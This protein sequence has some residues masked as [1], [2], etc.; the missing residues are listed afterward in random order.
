MLDVLDA[1][2]LDAQIMSKNKG[3][4]RHGQRGVDIRG[5]GQKPRN[6]PYEI[7]DPDKEEQGHDEGEKSTPF[8]SGDLHH[9]LFQTAH[10]QLKNILSPGR[11]QR[12][13]AAGSAGPD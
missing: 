3:A 2:V 13:A 4:Q 9:K 10:Q 6:Q 7:A 8:F 5:G 11:Y 12:N 1:M